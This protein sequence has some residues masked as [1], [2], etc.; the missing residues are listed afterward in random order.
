[1]VMFY[2]I[3]LTSAVSSTNLGS[4]LIFASCVLHRS[5][6]YSKFHEFNMFLP[7]FHK[8]TAIRQIL[9]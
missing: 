1:M 7:F 2:K 6:V 5:F 4:E 9:S 8:R 3:I